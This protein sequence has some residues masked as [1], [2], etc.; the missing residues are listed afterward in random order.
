MTLDTTFSH[1]SG[2]AMR[3]YVK[4]TEEYALFDYQ[5]EGVTLSVTELHAGKATRGHSHDNPELYIFQGDAWLQLGKQKHQVSKGEM[6]LVEAGIFHR[7]HAPPG[8]PTRFI[9]VFQ[10]S[11]DEK[12]A[13]YK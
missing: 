7:V 1:P 3:N 2:I 8:R 6:R 5:M 11:R 4:Q 13:T 10:G 9:A 12:R